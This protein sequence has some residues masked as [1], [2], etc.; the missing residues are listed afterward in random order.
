MATFGLLGRNTL[1]YSLIL[2]NGLLNLLGLQSN[3][4][5]KSFKRLMYLNDEIFL[6]LESRKKEIIIK[7]II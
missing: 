1:T 3:N 5:T 7:I 2:S 4:G 6:H